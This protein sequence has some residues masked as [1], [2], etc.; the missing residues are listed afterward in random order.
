[1]GKANS[2]K[3]KLTNRSVAGFK[4]RDEEYFVWDTETP[5][6][7]LRVY[8]T[9]KKSY[10]IQRM[11]G[12]SRKSIKLSLGSTSTYNDISEARDKAR[13]WLNDLA[14]GID[15]RHKIREQTSST[16]DNPTPQQLKIIRTLGNNLGLKRLGSYQ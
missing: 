10:C 11:L 3:R 8:P 1:M 14:E 2:T 5:S 4:A 16:M 15:P 12:K 13:E 7:F 9:G 6:F